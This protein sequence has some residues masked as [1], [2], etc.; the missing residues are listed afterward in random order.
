M[1]DHGVHPEPGHK[2]KYDVVISPYDFEMIGGSTQLV[3]FNQLRFCAT[4]PYIERLGLPDLNDLR[5][6]CLVVPK[7]LIQMHEIWNSLA[8]LEAE[9]ASSFKV[10]SVHESLFVINQGFGFGLVTEQA[11]TARHRVLEGFPSVE[12]PVY[13]GVGKEFLADASNAP[14][15]ELMTEQAQVFLTKQ[16]DD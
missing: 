1:M 8:A 9:C 12:H 15:I 7:L 14:L 16:V 11:Q 5:R 3:G 6:H 2:L 13:L 4:P 10:Q